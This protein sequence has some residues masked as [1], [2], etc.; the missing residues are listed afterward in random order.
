M[1]GYHEQSV[2][3][4]LATTR[5]DLD[6]EAAPPN[7]YSIFP[8]P[9]VENMDLAWKEFPDF[10]GPRNAGA[11]FG[12]WA[13]QRRGMGDASPHFWD[14]G[15]TSI[16]AWPHQPVTVRVHPTQ[17]GLSSQGQTPSDQSRD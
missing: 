5:G 7:P 15:K 8:P 1:A 14:K 9:L 16:S 6:R 10:F 11:N 3:D 4:Q 13:A 2:W 12:E 17:T